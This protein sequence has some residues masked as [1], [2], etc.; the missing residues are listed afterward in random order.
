M[1]FLTRMLASCIA[2]AGLLVAVTAD[3]RIPNYENSEALEQALAHSRRA[4]SPGVREETVR[5]FEQYLEEHP[6]TPNKPR[7]LANIGLLYLYAVA[8]NIGVSRDY[9]TAG[10][11]LR[12]AIEAD[13]DLITIEMIQARTNL[14]VI[15]PHGLAPRGVQRMRAGIETYKW[16]MDLT[17]EDIA[18]S[19][20]R[21]QE[22]SYVYGHGSREPE[23][24]SSEL[25][26]GLEERI[27]QTRERAIEREVA[28]LRGILIPHAR[29][30]ATNLV[31]D[32]LGDEFPEAA[33]R[34][35][36][37]ALKGYPAE[38]VVLQALRKIQKDTSDD[39]VS[40]PIEETGGAESQQNEQ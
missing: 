16:M 13:P 21:V 36:L 33:L 9:K 38:E 2:L 8:E 15:G 35:A 14:D 32:A 31:F 5:L 4:K 20:R 17:D 12:R 11:Y 29:S 10:E 37:A 1:W 27:E 39:I 30:T 25:P 23:Q 19:A 26:P 3:A 24:P 22:W 40:D 28:R 6:D 7:V 34:E 18:R